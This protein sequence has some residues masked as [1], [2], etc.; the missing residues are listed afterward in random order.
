VVASLAVDSTVVGRLAVVSIVAEADT[1]F[2]VVA[3]IVIVEVL[4]IPDLSDTIP[5][6]VLIAEAIVELDL[7]DNSSFYPLNYNIN[8]VI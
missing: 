1:V 8:K 4:P 5:A 3:K 7:V 6:S 2:W